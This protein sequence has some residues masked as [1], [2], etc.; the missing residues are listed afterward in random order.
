MYLSGGSAATGTA[1]GDRNGFEMI[2]T[3]QEHE[4]ANVIDGA[5]ATVFAGA[6][7]VG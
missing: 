5:L 4:P 7:I 2:F 6:S 3:G 1:F